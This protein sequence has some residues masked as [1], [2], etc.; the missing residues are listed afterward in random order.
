MSAPAY[1]ERAVAWLIPSKSA[2]G[3][4]ISCTL[5]Y[6]DDGTVSVDIY[7]ATHAGMAEHEVRNLAMAMQVVDMGDLPY[8][9]DGHHEQHGQLIH[10]G[11][12]ESE[13]R[14]HRASGLIHSKHRQWT[15][16]TDAIDDLLGVVEGFRAR[17]EDHL[18]PAVG[19]LSLS[20]VL[21]G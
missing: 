16:L 6:F 14:Y 3:R 9:L 17:A 13:L 5:A 18:C 8:P 1:E 15:L 4:P 12:T 7:D 2:S 19:G 11:V 21:F 20:D 10:K